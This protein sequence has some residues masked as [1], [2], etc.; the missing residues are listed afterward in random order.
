MVHVARVIVNRAASAHRREW[1]L[2]GVCTEPYQ[3]SCW[4]RN[5]P[6]YAKLVDV[7]L[8]DPDFR[9]CHMA[10]L[11]AFDMDA[12]KD[13]TVGSLHYLVPDIQPHVAWA[14][15]KTPVFIDSAHA[16]FNDVD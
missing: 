6:N 16:F 8:D 13:D 9:L 5:D 15:D 12:A 14:R 11:E 10:V 3:F 7:T 2:A 1:T 4:L